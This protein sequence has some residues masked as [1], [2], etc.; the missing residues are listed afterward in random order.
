MG[1]SR[2]KRDR[3]G[4][5]L[6]LKSRCDN[7]S[8][9]ARSACSIIPVPVHL[10]TICFLLVFRFGTCYSIISSLLQADSQ[11]YTHLFNSIFN[12]CSYSKKKLLYSP[13]MKL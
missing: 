10:F 13:L 7:Y 4:P 3:T 1:L 2:N 5:L 9:L 11:E 8:T 6:F 12:C